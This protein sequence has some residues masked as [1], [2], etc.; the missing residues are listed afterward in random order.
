MKKRHDRVAVALAGPHANYLNFR[1][2]SAVIHDTYSIRIHIQYN[3]VVKNWR[4]TARQGKS[5]HHQY[6]SICQKI[7]VSKCTLYFYHAALYANAVHAVI[8]GNA[9]LQILRKSI[10]N[11][12][13]ES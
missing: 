8:E 6:S 10:S 3:T 5:L 4:T 13:A 12:K 9:L 2:T 1:V 11:I 7:S